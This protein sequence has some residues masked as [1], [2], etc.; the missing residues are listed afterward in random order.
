V[1]EKHRKGHHAHETTDAFAEGWDACVHARPGESA[2]NP[3][4][5]EPA[6][7]CQPGRPA[8]RS[9]AR[10]RDAALWDQGWAARKEDL[11]DPARDEDVIA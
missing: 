6:A 7:L 3:Y 5:A 8:K 4:R 9:S 10:E 11:A 1:S 2:V